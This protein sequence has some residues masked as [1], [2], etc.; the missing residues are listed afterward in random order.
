ME[1]SAIRETIVTLTPDFASL[2][3]GYGFRRRCEGSEA[4]HCGTN[5]EAG[6]LRRFAPRNDGR[7][8]FAISPRLSREF[9]HQRPVLSDQRAQGMPGARCTRSLA[10]KI[11]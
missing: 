1:R 10:C 6:L 4:I 8:N 7:H 9:F 11:K 5:K 3:P 2:H